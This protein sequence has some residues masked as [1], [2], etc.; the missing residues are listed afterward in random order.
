[1]HHADGSVIDDGYLTIVLNTSPYTY[2]GN[3]PLDLAPEAT[4]DRGLAA[5]TVRTMDFGRFIRIIGSA[6]GSGKALRRS[7]WVDFRTDLEALTVR[8]YGPVPYQVDGDHL[9]DAEVL[10]FRHEPEV[11]DLVLPSP[12][13]DAPT[14]SVRS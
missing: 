9:G 8:T 10:E 13:D 12:T 5:V 14:R 11:L 2:L 1:V 3:R 6:L 4:L 7:R